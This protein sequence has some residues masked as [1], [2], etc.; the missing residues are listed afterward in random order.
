MLYSAAGQLQEAADAFVQALAID[1]ALAAAHG[2]A[3][4]NAALLGRP[5]ETLPAVERAMRLDPTDR[6]HSTWFFFGG[7]AELLLGRTEA[8]IALLEKSLERNP[9]YG[10]AQIFLMAAL[11]LIGRHSEA[12]LMAESFR[13]QYPE[14][15]AHAFA[16]LWLSRSTSPVYRAQVYPLFERIN[17]L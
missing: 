13:R 2:F 5:W 12:A 6:R 4:Y 16:Q 15:P 11:S 17:A 9:S 1:D 14:Y 10:S 8:A 7:F 3:G